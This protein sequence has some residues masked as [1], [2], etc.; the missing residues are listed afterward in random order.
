MVN[1]VYGNKQLF[2]LISIR[3]CKY[4]L[5]GLPTVKSGGHSPTVHWALEG[6]Y[7]PSVT[8]ELALHVFCVHLTILC[9]Q[10]TK[11]TAY[12]L[13]LCPCIAYHKAN[14][15]TTHHCIIWQVLQVVQSSSPLLLSQ[16]INTD[17]SRNTPD[18][19]CKHRYVM[20]AITAYSYI[21]GLKYKSWVRHHYFYL[22]EPLWKHFQKANVNYRQCGKWL[23]KELERST[24]KTRVRSQTKD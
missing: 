8:S 23:S 18:I 15:C 10:K 7:Q 17:L 2:T 9:T 3:T 1:A 21:T 22:W 20:L 4:K 11:F 19:C 24:T 14:R 6:K 13:S 16:Q 12:Y 5:Q